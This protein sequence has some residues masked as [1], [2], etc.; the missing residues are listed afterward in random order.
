MDRDTLMDDLDLIFER[1]RDDE[2][3]GEWEWDPPLGTGRPGRDRGRGAEGDQGDRHR[4][5]ERGASDSVE[6]PDEADDE[7]EG[8]ADDE[9]EDD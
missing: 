3:P 5:V 2:L 9:E 1:S 6:G 4:G 8:D 7:A